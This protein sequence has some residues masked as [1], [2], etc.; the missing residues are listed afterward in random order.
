MFVSQTSCSRD[1]GFLRGI[2]HPWGGYRCNRELT[3]LGG[4]QNTDRLTRCVLAAYTSLLWLNHRCYE[5][6]KPSL[7][8]YTALAVPPFRSIKLRSR[9]TTCPACGV[10]GEKVGKI[11]EMD[12]V[13]FCGG[14]RPD[15]VSRG[16]ENG[17]SGSRIHAKVRVLRACEGRPT[18]W[19]YRTSKPLLRTT[20]VEHESWM[21]GL[22]LN[23]TYVISL[24]H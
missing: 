22:A 24:A 9:R 19:S 12:Y 21:S 4:D 18:G 6:G 5:D 20:I 11:E 17:D 8:I 13:A 2:R 23:S 14:E 15:W 10:E 1:G 16:L 7:L 3:G